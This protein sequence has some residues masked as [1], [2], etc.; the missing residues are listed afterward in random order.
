[1]G[2]NGGREERRGGGS[3]YTVVHV[4]HLKSMNIKKKNYILQEPTII[5]IYILKNESF[6]KNLVKVIVH[7]LKARIYI[8]YHFQSVGDNLV[9]AENRKKTMI[10]EKKMIFLWQKNII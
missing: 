2:N 4:V 1:M 9:S 6:N 7:E 5:G 3:L 10:K 8:F